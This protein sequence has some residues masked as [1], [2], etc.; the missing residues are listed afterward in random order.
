MQ[1]PTTIFSELNASSRD[2][3][4]SRT[5]SAGLPVRTGLRAGI[6]LEEVGDQVSDWWNSLTTSLSN[7]VSGSDT[8]A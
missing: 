2:E 1:E 4:S 3:Q 6:T 5:I 8:S 7:A